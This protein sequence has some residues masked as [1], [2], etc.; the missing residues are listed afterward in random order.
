[1]CL[2]MDGADE[3]YVLRLT[4]ASYKQVKVKFRQFSTNLFSFVCAFRFH[5]FKMS[6]KVPLSLL[7]LFKCVCNE[8]CIRPH[9][10]KVGFK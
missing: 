6:G 10:Y 5:H 3:N 1:M 2:H 7:L 9:E 8:V 4:R